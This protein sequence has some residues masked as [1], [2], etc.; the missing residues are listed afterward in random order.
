MHSPA[1]PDPHRRRSPTADDLRV[2]RG[3]VE[4][5]ERLRSELESRLQSQSSISSGDYAVLLA[6]SEAEGRRMR[7]SELASHIRWERSRLS[8]HLAR[9]E[10]R[11]LVGRERCL[12]DSRGSEVVLTAEGASQFRRASATHLRAVQELFLDAFSP[13]Q[14]GRVDEIVSALRKHLGG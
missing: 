6:L 8:H 3:F 11:G 13:E 5:S 4:T 9:M 12:T 1:V 14:L 10:S 2:W 7:S